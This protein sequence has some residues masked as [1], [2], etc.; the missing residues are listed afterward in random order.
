[1]VPVVP[2]LVPQLVFVS[3]CKRRLNVAP[4]VTAVVDEVAHIILRMGQRRKVICHSSE[5]LSVSLCVEHA[6]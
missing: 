4:R 6:R 5:D 1:M 2:L 3:P